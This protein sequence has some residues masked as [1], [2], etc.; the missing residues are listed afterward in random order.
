MQ[1]ANFQQSCYFAKMHLFHFECFCLSAAVVFLN[2]KPIF[3]KNL[4]KRYFNKRT[5]KSD[6]F[7]FSF[8]CRQWEFL[9]TSFS[10]VREIKTWKKFFCILNS[11]LLAIMKD[12]LFTE[13]KKY[14]KKVW[15]WWLNALCARCVSAKPPAFSVLKNSYQPSGP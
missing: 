14:S 8:K 2:L 4:K 15:V 11:F 10:A 3:Q 13:E 12:N 5:N 6:H 7:F 1:K 9:R